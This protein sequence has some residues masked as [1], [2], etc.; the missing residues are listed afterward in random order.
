[1]EKLI[2]INP[3]CPEERKHE[4]L[5]MITSCSLEGYNYYENFTRY[6][7][8]TECNSSKNTG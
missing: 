2:V 1:M 8:W 4:R 7:L 3:F 6:I 5:D